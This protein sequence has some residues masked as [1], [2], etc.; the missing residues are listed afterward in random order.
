MAIAIS[1]TLSEAE[2]QNL[3]YAIIA[4]LEGRKEAPYFDNADPPQV[5]IGIGF[6]ISNEGLRNTVMA[7]MGLSNEA[8]IAVNNAWA[9]P[10]MNNIQTNQ[11]LSTYLSNAAGRPFVMTDPQIRN[12]FNGIVDG[13]DNTAQGHTH[14]TAF[15]LERAV[16]CSLQYNSGALLGPSLC[17]VSG[18][19]HAKLQIL[20]K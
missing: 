18:S 7:E 11:Q 6:D 17:S 20:H 1:R 15:S 4:K 16:F 9:A 2:Y 8:Q 14:V 19:G 13:Y 3:R 10:A 12:V 5:T